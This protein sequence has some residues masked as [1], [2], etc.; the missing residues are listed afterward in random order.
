MI[1]AAG[2]RF[3]GVSDEPLS[4]LR[5]RCDGSTVSTEERR[6]SAPNQKEGNLSSPRPAPA[7][8]RRKRTFAA[9]IA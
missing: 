6:L 7:Q 2:G 5:V 1:F 9:T 4:T 3:R 8:A